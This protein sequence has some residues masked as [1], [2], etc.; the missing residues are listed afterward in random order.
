MLELLDDPDEE[1]YHT[2]SDRI[3]SLGKAI[4]PNLEHRWE[5]E[6]NENIQERIEMLIHRLH[7]RDLTDEFQR[8]MNDGGQHLLS[9]AMMV[10]KYHYPEIAAHT[11][12][13]E[14]E[15]L[16][17]SIWL[18]LNQYLTG[19]EK[20]SIFNS[21]FYNYY[22]Q[23]GVETQYEN[24]DP[25]LINKVLE[26][27]SGNSIGNGVVYL[28]LCDLLDLPVSAI[29]LPGQFILACFEDSYRL[30][31]EEQG[32]SRISFFIDPLSGQMYSRQDV[33]Q[34]MKKTNL[35]PAETYFQPMDHR[36]VIRTL[37]EELAKCFD[38]DSNRYKR[39]ELM[40]LAQLLV[41]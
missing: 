10:A 15:K 20:I 40:S 9:G 3:V 4:I 23:I 34:Y 5:Q 35:P 2:V 12:F 18:E 30:P 38:N 32:P 1:V 16:R 26:Q 37:L 21:I 17:R 14:V 24:P 36:K 39:D 19:M 25:F 8:W 28:I 6:H 27:R 11:V 7:F 22:K 29:Q 33:D 41:E 13:Q 31:G